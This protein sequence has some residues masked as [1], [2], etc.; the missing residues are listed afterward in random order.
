MSSSAVRWAARV[1]CR[2]RSAHL[3]PLR[4]TTQPPVACGEPVEA[5][6]GADRGA[7]NDL[8]AGALPALAALKATAPPALVTLKRRSLRQ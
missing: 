8:D 5:D 1:P 6:D 7:L 4:E 3:D 2:S